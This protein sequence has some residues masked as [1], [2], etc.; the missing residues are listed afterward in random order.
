V[1]F[2]L[3]QS[4]GRQ[5]G[6]QEFTNYFRNKCGVSIFCN[7]KIKRFIPE[8]QPT[9]NAEWRSIIIRFW[10]LSTRRAGGRLN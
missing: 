8:L 2:Y 9:L 5:D 6:G 3:R 10:E 1:S 7:A 4:S